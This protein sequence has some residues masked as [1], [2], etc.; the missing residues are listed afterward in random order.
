M[1]KS[2]LIGLVLAAAAAAAAAGE[3]GFALATAGEVDPA[4]AE[5]IRARL[6]ATSG[7]AVRLA[8][9]VALEE[10][11]TL[12]AIGRAA[13]AALEPGDHSVIV[14]ARAGTGQPQ[15]VC[16]PHVRFAALNLSRLEA[17][18]DAA[19]LE[20]R[21][22]QEG[23]RVMAML[24][25]MSPCPFPLCLLVGYDQLED[26]DRMS[27]NY[28]PPCQDRFERI[29]REAGLRVADRDPAPAAE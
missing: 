25:G 23:L 13:A 1:K 2:I 21:A 26:L 11:Q 16:L 24:L 8:A 12:E 22:T 29:A 19:Q 28:C 17:G 6:E 18:A 10:G 7:A 5:T 15:G 20:R 14:L 4:W 3:R 27:G 9:P